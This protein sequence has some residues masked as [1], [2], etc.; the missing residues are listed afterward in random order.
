ML[1]SR[2]L[3]EECLEDPDP[4][5]CDVALELMQTEW[6]PTPQA[7]KVAEKR[8]KDVDP[9]IRRIALSVVSKFYQSNNPGDLRIRSA[10]ARVVA[11]EHEDSENRF[12]A[13]QELCDL[14][15]LRVERWP[16]MHCFPEEFEPNRDVDWEFVRSFLEL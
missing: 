10:F 3:T 9:R 5:V 4:A 13:Y 14:C 2:I 16:I 15:G 1:H 8:M 11:D 12:V 7:A 6:Q